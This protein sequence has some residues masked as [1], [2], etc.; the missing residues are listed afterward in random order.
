MNLIMIKSVILA[1][2]HFRSEPATSS[3]SLSAGLDYRSRPGRKEARENVTT[4]FCLRN[5]MNRA[6]VHLVISSAQR[7]KIPVLLVAD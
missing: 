6:I 2:I 5:E 1:D 3:I 7:R 4:V